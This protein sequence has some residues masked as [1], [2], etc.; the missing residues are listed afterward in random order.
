M[1]LEQMHDTREGWLSHGL[2]VMSGR[3]AANGYSLPDK[4]KVACGFAPGARGGKK[5][6][7][8]CIAPEASAEGIT[9]IFI[10]PIISDPVTALGAVLAMS[11]HAAG[12]GKGR[13]FKAFCD[14]VGLEGKSKAVSPDASCRRWLNDEVLPMLGAYPHAAVDPSKR[15]K[16]GT[17][18][19]KL[20]CLETKDEKGNHYTVRMTK[21][22]LDTYGA[23]LSPRGFQMVVD[24][25][26][27]GEE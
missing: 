9:E 7:A 21:K 17:R 27:A 1:E 11:G 26:D 23:P 4:V 6:A 15:A 8:V 16:Q 25:E 3:L 19:I 24:G 13:A 18:M 14:A 22:W 10:S 20:I 2:S 5:T 12:K